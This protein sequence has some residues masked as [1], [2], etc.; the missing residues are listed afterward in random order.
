LLRAAAASPLMARHAEKSQHQACAKA[1]LAAMDAKAAETATKVRAE[2]KAAY[3]AEKA[4]QPATAAAGEPKGP[5]PSASAPQP[6]T[7]GDQP[8]RLG[9]ADLRRAFQERKAAQAAIGG[10]A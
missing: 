5:R 2:Q 1:S 9:L 8:R 6:V 7:S 3:L 4:K 10:A